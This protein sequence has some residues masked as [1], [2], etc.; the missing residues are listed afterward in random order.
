MSIENLQDLFV[1]ELRDVLDAERQLLK[2]LPKL[3]KAS[4]SA[5]LKAAFEEHAS[6]TEEQIG[7]I[8]TIF[9]S[10][11]MAARGKHCVGMEGLVAEGSELI[12]EEEKGV[13]LDAALICAAQKAEH[14]EISAYG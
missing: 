3:A 10:L 5:E 4:E 12:K 11:D 6:V 1:H 9:K 2:A 7:R 13:Q 8:E 14:Y